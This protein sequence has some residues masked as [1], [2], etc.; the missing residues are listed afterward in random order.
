ML[1]DELTQLTLHNFYDS[2]L[3]CRFALLK[4]RFTLLKCRFALLN[5]SNANAL[6]KCRS[7]MQARDLHCQNTDLTLLSEFCNYYL[8]FCN[9][10]PHNFFG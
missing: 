9:Q 1:R 5:C 6:L 8:I 10:T 7:A 3:K 2:I 4:C